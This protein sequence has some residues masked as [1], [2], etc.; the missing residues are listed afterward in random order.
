MEWISVND[1]M[2]KESKVDFLGVY[3]SEKVF[4]V[5]EFEEG[6]DIGVEQ[7]INGKWDIESKHDVKVTHWMKCPELPER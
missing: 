2:P 5:I 7:T 4:V 6:R 1:E 3:A